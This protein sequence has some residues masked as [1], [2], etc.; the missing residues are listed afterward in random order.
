MSDLLH[1]DRYSLE[2]LVAIMSR[3]RDPRSG[4]PWDREQS[5]AT[6]RSFLLEETYEVLEAMEG[7]DPG[8]HAGELGDLLFQIVFQSQIAS[9]KG[10]FDLGEVIDRISRKLVRRHP[11]VFGDRQ[12]LTA[13]E[14]PPIWE[15]IKQQEKAEAGAPRESVLDGLP[16]ALPALLLAH[17]VSERAARVGF[18]WENPDQVLDKIKEETGELEQA[19]AIPD[20]EQKHR[21]I[22]WEIGDLL[23]AATNLARKCNLC[24]EDLLR[25][26]NHRFEQRFRLVE[27]LARERGLDMPTTPLAVLEAL[28]TEAKARLRA[29]T[30]Q[31]S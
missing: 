1:K 16:A 4:C 24:S 19:L 6:L 25:E 17:R 18:D 30:T 10:Q 5:I 29:E 20:A 21:E 2:D 11:H 23:F 8:E 3:L 31:R 28:W 27:Q 26:A 7:N 22:A 15:Q 14:V 12:A 9:E 13:A